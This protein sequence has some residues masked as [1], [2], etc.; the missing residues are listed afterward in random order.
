VESLFVNCD[1]NDNFLICGDYN[2]PGNIW[3]YIVSN[4]VYRRQSNCQPK[5]LKK[6][7]VAELVFL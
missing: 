4:I 3:Q 5:K 2:L 6:S 7:P 1:V